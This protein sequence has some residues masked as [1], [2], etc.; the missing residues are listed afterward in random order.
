MSAPSESVVARAAAVSALL[1]GIGSAF[2]L[3]RD[4]LVG[5]LF[6]ANQQTDAF[7]VAWTVPEATAPLLIE[8]TMAFVMV[9]AFGRALAAAES[10]AQGRR[11]GK[12]DDDGDPMRELI[13]ATFLRIVV[14]LGLV[15]VLIAVAAPWLIGVLAPGLED[16]GLATNCL[17]AVAVT[18]PLFGI[19]GYLAA[20]LRTHYVFAPPAALNLAYNVGIIT[21]ILLTYQWLGVLGAA[22]GISVGAVLMVVIQ[23]PSAVR[24][25]PMPRTFSLR[26]TTTLLAFA[27]FLPVAAHSLARQAQVLV[28]RFAAAPPAWFGAPLAEGTI[29]HLNYAQKIA[30]IPIT[31]SFMAAAVTF[32]IFAK[33][34][35]SG[36]LHEARRR[37]EIDTAVLGGIAL[38]VIAYLSLYATPVVEVLFQRREFDAEDTAATAAILHVYVLGILGQALVSLLVRPFFTY[39]SRIWFPAVA[40]LWG[41]L[42]TVVATFLLV[43]PFGAQGIAGANALGISVTAV[44]LAVGARTRLSTAPTLAAYGRMALLAVPV[45]IAALAGLGVHYLLAGAPA[46]VLAGVGGIVMVAVACGLV[47][48]ALRWRGRRA[49]DP[50]GRP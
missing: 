43:G 35:A 19:A 27:A 10:A 41:L 18:V 13:E 6:G 5:A 14:G 37:M 2:G 12:L 32:P 17:R 34:V 48:L 11:T 45:G 38:L 24:R 49:L 50:G 44:I 22:I 33:S 23:A 28:E 3:G 31:L 47:V 9:P 1:A 8:G 4:V 40:M 21:T 7:F 15:A 42:V 36:S 26:K 20:G 30:Q 29:S 39:Q 25:L 46:I 16:P